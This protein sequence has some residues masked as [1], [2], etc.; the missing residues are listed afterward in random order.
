VDKFLGRDWLIGMESMVCCATLLLSQDE[1]YF[2]VDDTS[3]KMEG[4]YT[5]GDGYDALVEVCC[6]IGRARRG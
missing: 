5:T 3:A 1:G 6:P 4:R 2:I